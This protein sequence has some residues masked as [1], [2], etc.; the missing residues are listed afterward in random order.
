MSLEE[1]AFKLRKKLQQNPTQKVAREIADE[2]KTITDAKGKKLSKKA[3]DRIIEI[4]CYGSK[5]NGKVQLRDS[6]NSIF[7]KAVAVLK[8][9]INDEGGNE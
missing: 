2:I 3:I 1:Y 4:I 8:S 6:D 7:L 9:Y 5:I